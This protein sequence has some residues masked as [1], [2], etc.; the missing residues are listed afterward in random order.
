MKKKI[1]VIATNACGWP[2][3]TKLKNGQILCTYFN[4]PS[5]GLMEGNL[6][7]SISDRKGLNWRKRSVVAKHPK[8]GNRM[9]LAVGM[10]NNGDLLCFSSGFYVKDEKFTGFSGHWLSRSTDRGKTWV[11][12][13]SPQIPNIIKSSIPFGRIISIGENK[14]AYSSYRS[15]GRGNPSESWLVVSE[16]D[17]NSWNKVSKFGSNDS[18]EATICYLTD[19]RLLAAV[20]THVDHHVKLCETSLLNKRWKEKGPLSLPMQHPADV[21]QLSDNCLLLTYGI[22]NRGLMGIGARLSIDGG[23]TWRSPWVIHQFGNK[24]KDVGY[25]SSVSLDKNGTLLTAF[26]CDYE[27][28]FKKKPNLYRVLSLKWS[29]KDWLDHTV[30]RFVSD[31]KLLK[32]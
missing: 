28:T 23:R 26:Y 17:G 11:V 12:D 19:N 1:S 18:N 4:A 32:F 13:T 8:G 5:H 3:L 31:G 25:P 2:N 22:R 24:A 15:K 6:V 20:R 9:H 7:S 16:D 10:A 29:L 21:I 27:P 14:L 30:F